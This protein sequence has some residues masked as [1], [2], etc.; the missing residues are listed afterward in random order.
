MWGD[1][2]SSAY[3][4]SDKGSVAR[5]IMECGDR[6]LIDTRKRKRGGEPFFSRFHHVLLRLMREKKSVEFLCDSD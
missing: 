2:G 4:I 6:Y 1:K 3:D 5:D